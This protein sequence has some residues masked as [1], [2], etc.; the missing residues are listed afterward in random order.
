MDFPGTP[1]LPLLHASCPWAHEVFS[2]MDSKQRYL[3][4]SESSCY[5]FPSKGSSWQ[6]LST[7]SYSLNFISTISLNWS[8]FFYLASSMAPLSPFSFIESVNSPA[9]KGQVIPNTACVNFL[10]LLYQS[11]MTGRLEQQKFIF[12]SFQRLEFKIK[13]GFLWGLSLACRCPPSLCVLTWSPL[14]VSVS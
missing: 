14:C 7:F 9:F 6:S 11:T 12:S 3:C 1:F 10:G 8:C 4:W 13:I 5:S 2:S